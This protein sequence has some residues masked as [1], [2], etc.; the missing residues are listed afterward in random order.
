MGECTGNVELLMDIARY[1]CSDVKVTR[2]VHW[3]RATAS[4]A[5]TT[6]K[7]GTRKLPVDLK[8]KPFPSRNGMNDE[9]AGLWLILWGFPGVGILRG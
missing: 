6:R 2:D 7:W 8:L 4:F 3:Y 5:M 9:M 1:R